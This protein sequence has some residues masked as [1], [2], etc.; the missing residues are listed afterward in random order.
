MHLKRLNK[1]TG[2]ELLST[3]YK[4]I[5]VFYTSI[6]LGILSYFFLLKMEWTFTSHT[7]S[8]LILFRRLHYLVNHTFSCVCL[9]MPVLSGKHLTQIASKLKQITIL[10]DATVSLYDVKPL[11]RRGNTLGKQE[12]KGKFDHVVLP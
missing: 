12:K 10:L 7:K 2:I 5:S 8:K 4:P 9:L 1:L 11:A 6:L 3:Q